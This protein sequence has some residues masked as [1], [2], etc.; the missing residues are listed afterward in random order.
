MVHAC[1]VCRGQF[2]HARS[3]WLGRVIEHGGE[4]GI[5]GVAPSSS[6][7]VGSVDNQERAVGQRNLRSDIN[8]CEN[9]THAGD[10]ATYEIWEKACRRLKQFRINTVALLKV[11]TWT[12]HLFYSPLGEGGFGHDGNA[13][14]KGDIIERCTS[15]DNDGHRSYIWSLDG[16]NGSSTR[17]WL[18]S[19][20]VEVTRCDS[21]DRWHY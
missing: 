20:G 2:R 5:P 14:V 21:G 15:A 16:H 12:Y 18:R 8:G 11:T 4:V 1:D 9:K 3:D 13:G 19:G 7:K 6:T 17:P 10:Q